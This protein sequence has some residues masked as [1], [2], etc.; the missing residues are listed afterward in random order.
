[1]DLA[2]EYLL[3]FVASHTCTPCS[4]FSFV[5]QHFSSRV[6]IKGAGAWGKGNESRMQMTFSSGCNGTI[7]ETIEK[8]Q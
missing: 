2:E 6:E 4:L 7:E 1:M 3:N 8:D 5:S